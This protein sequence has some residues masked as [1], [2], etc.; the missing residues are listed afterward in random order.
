MSTGW[1]LVRPWSPF[2]MIK[3]CQINNWKC[4]RC[5]QA[6]G[7][8]EGQVEPIGLHACSKASWT[9][10]PQLTIAARNI[11]EHLS[12]ATRIAAKNEACSSA[13]SLAATDT[14]EVDLT[15]FNYC[16]KTA[17]SSLTAGWSTTREKEER[18]GKEVS[19]E[20][21]QVKNSLLMPCTALL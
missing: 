17:T 10:F 15:Q 5:L 8:S 18:I 1:T 7:R 16:R 9:S 6:G 3:L 14:F 4:S 21:K 11:C 13:S 2:K 20:F 19:K 12:S